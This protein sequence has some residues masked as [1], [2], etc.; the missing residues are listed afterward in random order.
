MGDF[1]AVQDENGLFLLS[2][3]T[4]Y[5]PFGRS[6]GFLSQLQMTDGNE[7]FEDIHLLG[8]R[9]NNTCCLSKLSFQKEKKNTTQNTRMHKKEVCKREENTQKNAFVDLIVK[10]EAKCD[11]I[12]IFKSIERAGSTVKLSIRINT[13]STGLYIYTGT[14]CS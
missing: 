12:S 10:E 2:I 4:A 1:E 8:T 7:I 9:K 13:W 14:K 6:Q 11:Y 3:C 5:A